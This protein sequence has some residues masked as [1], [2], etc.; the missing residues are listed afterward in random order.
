MIY[1]VSDLHG[2][3]E[4]FKSLLCEISFKDSDT[5]YILGDIVDH[6]ED[7]IGLICDISMR[8]NVLPILGECD[9]RAL[10]LLEELDRMLRGN[11]PDPEIIPRLA[12]WMQEGGKSTIEGFKALDEDMREGVIDYISDMAL[13]EELT[14]KGQKYLLMHAGIADFDPDAELDEYMP[15]DFITEPLDPDAKYFDDTVMI[16]GHTYTG[17][18][19]KAGRIYHAPSGNIFIDCGGELGETIGCLCLDDGKEFY[20]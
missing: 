7:P 14:V 12:E 20:V 9:Y 16:V 15:E 6:G 3:Y 5:M 19:G 17:E 11:A 4:K 10:P 1:V 2:N 8:Y 13:Y 18:L